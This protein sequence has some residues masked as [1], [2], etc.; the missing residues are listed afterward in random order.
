ML[1]CCQCHFKDGTEPG[2]SDCRWFGAVYF[3]DHIIT[4]YAVFIFSELLGGYTAAELMYTLAGIGKIFLVILTSQETST[5]I[6][7]CCMMPIIGAIKAQLFLCNMMH[8]LVQWNLSPLLT[9]LGPHE[10]S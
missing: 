8:V 3:L 2:T 9:H 6:T 7:Q 10:V 4:I 1:C 5:T